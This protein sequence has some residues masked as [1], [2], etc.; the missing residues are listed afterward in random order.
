MD[1]YI[2]SFCGAKQQFA[3]RNRSEWCIHHFT[4]WQAVQTC[5]VFAFWEF[6]KPFSACRFA[7]LASPLTRSLCTLILPACPPI[8]PVG[9]F[10]AC[11]EGYQSASPCKRISQGCAT[12]PFF[13][14]WTQ[15]DTDS[16]PPPN[17]ERRGQTLEGVTTTPPLVVCGQHQKS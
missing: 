15:F 7:Y 17:G 16:D 5:N 1:T 13:E 10:G 2:K 6:P 8:P 14:N 12:Q 4:T 3:N 11:R 9:C